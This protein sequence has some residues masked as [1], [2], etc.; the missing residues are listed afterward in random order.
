LSS[1]KVVADGIEIAEPPVVREG[2]PIKLCLPVSSI[3]KASDRATNLGGHVDSTPDEWQG[4]TFRACD[5]HDPEGS[6]IQLREAAPA[7]PAS[8]RPLDPIP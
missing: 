5:G 2:M 1:P 6:I 3:A 8:P 7:G 4:P